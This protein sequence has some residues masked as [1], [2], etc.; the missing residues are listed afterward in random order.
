[1]ETTI[2]GL[3]FRSLVL[4]FNI[5]PERMSSCFGVG[6]N[7]MNTKQRNEC[8]TDLVSPFLQNPFRLKRVQRAV[9]SKFGACRNSA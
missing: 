8:A 1:M 2:W 7:V 9:D 4:M 3:G 6:Q 5:P